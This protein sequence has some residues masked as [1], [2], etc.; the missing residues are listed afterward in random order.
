MVSGTNTV[1]SSHVKNAIFRHLTHCA[2]PLDIRSIQYHELAGLMNHYAQA[3]EWGMYYVYQR[4]RAA[5]DGR[6]HFGSAN[7]TTALASNHLMTFEPMRFDTFLESS[8][9]GF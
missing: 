3:E 9:G 8:W 6:W 7:L 5:A 2:G 1:P 4:L